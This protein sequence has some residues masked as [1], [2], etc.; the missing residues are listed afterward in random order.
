M[1]GEHW[2]RKWAF[3]RALKPPTKTV[4][5][6]QEGHWLAAHPHRAAR[7]RAM[8]PWRTWPNCCSGAKIIET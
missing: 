8:G 4:P 3:K 5:L 2:E 6:K 7:L 1:Q